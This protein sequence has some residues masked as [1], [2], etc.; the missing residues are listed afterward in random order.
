[1]KSSFKRMSGR[2]DGRAVEIFWRTPELVERLLPYL[3]T[4]S[5]SELARA[6]QL[7]AQLLQGTVSWN[8][9]VARSCP[10]IQNFHV[11]P[12]SWKWEEQFH[13][14]IEDNLLQ[15]RTKIGWLITILKKMKN[16]K[17]SL[18]ELLHVICERFPPVAYQSHEVC[19]LKPMLFC[20]SCP[21][22]R[23]HPVSHLG[24]LL[25]EEVEGAL[26][27]ALQEL[28]KVYLLNIEEPWLAAICS[29]MSRQ[30]SAVQKLDAERFVCTNAGHT[31]ALIVLQKSCKKQ[32]LEEV[33]VLGNIGAEGW[34]NLARACEHL[35]V[36]TFNASREAMRGAR[37]E[38]LR[39]VW[40]ALAY[41]HPYGLSSFYVLDVPFDD[42][43]VTIE[44]SWDTDD[45]KENEWRDLQELLDTP[46][47]QWPSALK[48][49]WDL[50]EEEE[51]QFDLEDPHEFI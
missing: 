41:P 48:I 12:S 17:A 43:L 51:D 4:R 49:K 33:E 5:V 50:E 2:E 38:D 7:T 47:E 24:F 46:P 28:E 15:H 21:C 39:I 10:Y 3:D 19:D 25:L 22:K 44:L 45:D 14:W 31:K 32:E 11:A 42:N 26:G 23:S 6:H 30:Q 37:R 20:V 27:S 35:E 36:Y 34:A 16:P 29:R 18:L 9:L 40:D 1:M 13:D 8:N